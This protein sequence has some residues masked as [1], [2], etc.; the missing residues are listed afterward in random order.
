MKSNMTGRYETEGAHLT[1]KWRLMEAINSVSIYD[2]VQGY[3]TRWYP[4]RPSAV[5]LQSPGSLV[6]DHEL[7]VD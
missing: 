4:G 3:W 5:S 7:L 1:I 6:A 2:G